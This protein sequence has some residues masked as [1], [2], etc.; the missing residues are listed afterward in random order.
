[1]VPFKRK[2]IRVKIKKKKIVQSIDQCAGN[3]CR[4][5][6]FC[7]SLSCLGNN[8]SNLILKFPFDP[9]VF[10]IGI[11]SFATTFCAPGL[12]ISFR[13]SLNTRPS[14]VCSSTVVPVNASRNDTLHVCTK[15]FPSLVNVAW[16]FSSTTKMMSAGMRPGCSSPFS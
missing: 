8:T 1:M 14:N 13:G 11:P 3:A 6:S 9:G 10:E 5:T 15:S 7:A 16:G 4:N 12:T 2:K